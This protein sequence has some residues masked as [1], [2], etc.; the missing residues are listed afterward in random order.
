MY[1]LSNEIFNVS[2]NPI[3]TCNPIRYLS[4]NSPAPKLLLLTLTL[5][6][7]LTQTLNI[8]L[9][10]ILILF[11]TLTLALTLSL[12]FNSG[13]GELT[14]KN[15][16]FISSFPY[17]KPNNTCSKRKRCCSAALVFLCITA[18]LTFTFNNSYLSP[19][20]D[21]DCSFFT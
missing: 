12:V 17:P 4:V 13:G 2:P 19:D 15:L 3:C 8:T 18:L 6:L 10:L 9:T 1:L 20:I 14:Y 5:T 21:L 7:I 16:L 11:L